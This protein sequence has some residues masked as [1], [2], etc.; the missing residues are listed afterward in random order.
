MNSTGGLK[1]T[2]QGGATKNMNTMGGGA[3]PSM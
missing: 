1:K 2:M 3:V